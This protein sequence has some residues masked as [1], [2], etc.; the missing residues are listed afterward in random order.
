VGCIAA[1][2]AFAIA[3]CEGA[4]GIRGPAGADGTPGAAGATGPAGAQGPAGVSTGT[5]AGRL[6]DAVRSGTVVAGATVT[7]SPGNLSGQ[8]GTDGTYSVQLP[9]GVF[10]AKYTATGY[11]DLTVTDIPVLPGQTVTRDVVMQPTNPLVANAGP[12]QWQA[13]FGATVTLNGTQSS[14]PTG[15]TLTYQWRQLTGPTVTLSDATAASPTFATKTLA[16]LISAQATQFTLPSRFGVLGFT[17]RDTAEMSYT[18]ELKVAG[19]GFEKTAQVTIQ[20]VAAHPGVTN[21]PLNHKTYLNAPEQSTY[22]WTCNKL[23]GTVETACAEGVLGGPTTRNPLF[24]PTVEGTYLLREAAQTAPLKVYAGSYIGSRSAGTDRTRC[25]GCHSGTFT[26]GGRTVT[27]HYN[28]WSQTK[29]ATYFQ[30]ALDGEISSHYNQSCVKCHTT[31][32]NPDADNGGFDDVARTQGWTFPT[33]LGAGTYAAMSPLLKSLSS[34]GCETCHGPGSQ[35]ASFST[36]EAIG[37][38]YS[39]NDCN[40]CHANEPYQAQ[41]LQWAKS[42]H[43]TFIN[44]LDAPS[45]GDPALSGTCTNCHSS[46]GFVAWVKT[47]QNS[48]AQPAL[49]AEPQTC[50]TCH[51]PHGEAK[52]NGQPTPHLL[53]VYGNVTTLVPGLGA[54]NVGAGAVCMTCHNSRKT[55]STT[56]QSAP[57]APA[58]SDILLAKNAAQFSLGSY[59]SSPHA[60][61]PGLCVG[62]HMAPTPATGQP[63]HNEL[64]AHTFKVK[65]GNVENLVACTSCHQSLEHFNRTAYADFDGDGVIE[66]IQDEVRGLINLV[67]NAISAKA[68][69]LWPTETGGGNPRVVGYHGRIRLLKNYVSGTSPAN[70]NPDVAQ[71]WPETCFAF[72]S[73]GIPTTTD[74]MKNVIGA[75]WNVLLVSGDRSMGIHNPA[76]A[77]E[78]LQRSYKAITG[79]D[80]PGAT[81]RR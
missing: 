26:V 55:F 76:Y 34:V 12:T 59:G 37:K 54:H 69:T 32:F 71:E 53:R 31:G 24:L 25:E 43:A 21:V 16:E 6:T 48:Q 15:V 35:H 56:S 72:A 57:H 52:W 19:G 74:E 46:Q 78:V 4:P 13:G 65:A 47:G 45:V 11:G 40:Q 39:A 64:G 20:S 50:A 29:H 33:T 7:F 60:T 49:K 23:S 8:S 28:P 41:G 3:G 63:G 79:V 38:S 9:P 2:L 44:D 81:L 61:V 18:F 62:C 30:R 58:Q 42:G 14:A 17:G 75:A 68:A 5:V 22:A 10:S 70:C 51:D 36:L 80:V 66:G 67:N 1:A 73:G 27:D 77:V